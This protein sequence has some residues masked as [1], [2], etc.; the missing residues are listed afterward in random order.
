MYK[1]T[2]TGHYVR[3]GW[4]FFACNTYIYKAGILV[5]IWAGDE[6]IVPRNDQQIDKLEYYIENNQH[7]L[8][9]MH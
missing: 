4:Y 6:I 7:K 9:M 5:P 8:E 1:K 3:I 2:T